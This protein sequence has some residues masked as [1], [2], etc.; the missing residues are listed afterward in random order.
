MDNDNIAKDIKQNLKN[1]YYIGELIYTNI[2][3]RTSIY[4]LTNKLM[5]GRYL[6]NI[7]LFVSLYVGVI[8]GS[9]EPI[10]KIVSLVESYIIRECYRLYFIPVFPRERELRG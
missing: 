6:P 10:L 2:I 1:I 3:K 5:L 4:K 7:N 9:N 8:S